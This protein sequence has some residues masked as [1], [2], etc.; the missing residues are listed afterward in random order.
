LVPEPKPEFFGRLATIFQHRADQLEKDPAPATAADKASR[1]ELVRKFRTQAGDAYIAL[2]RGLILADDRGQGQALWKG[3]ALYDRAGATMQSIA[4]LETFITE[5]PDD[6]TTPDALLRLGRAY[7]ATGQFD[8]AIQAFQREQFRYPQSLAASQS[9]VP[10]AQAFIA[11][12]PASYP[13][14]ERALHAVLESKLITP[15]AE[16]F[17]LALFEL[18]QLYYRTGRYEEAIS[19]LEETTKRYPSD[20][21]MAQLIFMMADSY[22]KSAVLL[23][24]KLAAP[25]TLP[26]NDRS[27]AAALAARAEADAAHRER[28]TKAKTL[29]GQIVES[30]RLTPPTR[31]LDKLYLKLSHFYRADCFYDL[32]DYEQA[33]RHYDAATSRYQDDPS[34]VAAS[35]QIVNCYCRLGRLDDARTA[36]ERAKW[37]LQKMPADAFAEGKSSMPKK[38]WDDWLRL[39]GESGLYAK[40]LR[41]PVTDAR[42]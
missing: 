24:E 7:H 28:L 27:N 9:G 15:D 25:T 16:E 18:A 20:P 23:G 42:N 22:R 30:S 3:V 14:A 13:S 11:K 2:S 41:N 10:L 12:G 29:F 4:A 31:E 37:L 34:A 33:V 5:R 39:T 40:D 26:A 6:S 36:N 19:H 21:R 17:R 38:Y 35:V 32:G 1:A 8:K